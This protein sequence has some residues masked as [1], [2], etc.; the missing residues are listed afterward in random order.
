VTQ[1]AGALRAQLNLQVGT[2]NTQSVSPDSVSEFLSQTVSSLD[3]SGAEYGT[4]LLK[5]KLHDQAYAYAVVTFE[6]QQLSS[7]NTYINN[8]Q[9]VAKQLAATDESDTLAYA[10]LVEELA[11]REDQLS[12][13]IGDQFHASQISI[14][15]IANPD[16]GRGF[17]NEILNIYDSDQNNSDVI[18]QIAAIEVNFSKIFE[19][20]HNET[21][22]PHCIALAQ[23]DATSGF[24]E[25]EQP[26][27]S[28]DADDNDTG[29][30][31]D[32]DSKATTDTSDS[33]LEPLRMSTQWDF[34]GATN[35][36]ADGD[37][38]LTYSYYDGDVAYADPYNGN[39]G[40]PPANET[41]VESH[42]TGNEA[43]LDDAFAAWDL[44]SDFTFQEVEE[45]GGE[46]G[47]LRVAY[48]DEGTGAAAFA[49]APGSSAVSGDIWF[50]AGSIDI[51]GAIDFKSDGIDELSSYYSNGSGNKPGFNYFAALHEIGH[52]LGLSHP[53]DS[54]DDSSNGDDDLP[55]SQDSM[56]N[57]VMT[58][59][60]LDRNMILQFDTGTS[61][62]LPTYR[63]WASTPMLYD[64]EM[65][66][67]YYGAEDDLIDND[68][69]GTA[70]DTYTFGITD[71]TSWYDSTLTIQ[72]IVDSGGT[73]TIDTSALSRESVIDLTAG[74][75]SSIGIY[76]EADQVSY[77]ATT[78]GTSTAAIQSVVDTMDG[79]A[80]AANS[81][82]SAYDR[83]A[84]Y[85]GDYNVAIAHNAVI[86]NAIGGSAND[87][88]TGNSSNNDLSGRAGDDRIEGNGGDDTIDGGTHTTGDVAVY[89]GAYTE[90]TITDLGG[91][92]YT[93]DH[94]GGSGSDG[95]DTISNIEFLE[96]TDQTIDLSTW[97]TVTSTSTPSGIG[98]QDTA[99]DPVY[100]TSDGANVTTNSL[101]DVDIS[102]QA[103]ALSAITRL[104]S[105][106]ETISKQQAYMGAMQ[107]R[108]A[109]S[110][111]NLSKQSLM[112][113]AAIGRIMDTDFSSE[114]AELTKSMILSEAANYV[115]SGAQL[116]KS[117][118]LK[119]LK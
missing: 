78:L 65:M 41:T 89:N 110:I 75:L 66:E 48:T 87:T 42:G 103:G 73:D 99:G 102:T 93:V 56:R 74:S 13:F 91:G 107:N 94:T 36:D 12:S 46:V 84:L 112:T 18:G 34:A 108:L 71:V 1:F 81:Y 90:Y 37:P 20:L 11:D 33:R 6:E 57:T 88:I 26:R 38:I 77:W 69:D 24:N 86:E 95:T 28:L 109:A 30:I 85:T 83:S 50:E 115:L 98:S 63:I 100:A 17:Q 82:Y 68:S 111:S 64:V 15:A 105:V 114:M 113:E 101:A 40:G 79:Y 21:T 3:L 55:L 25:D 61:S 106:L 62:S 31:V 2:E 27:F 67:H 80:S 22:C 49:Y 8:V 52:A 54:G 35:L 117:N 104:D 29:S 70:N 23:Q 39:V 47:E 92:M 97:P 10:A 14:G 19:T 44:A 7:L 76:S 32:I 96:F 119:L 53:F 9:S 16:L 60:Q 116:S 72:T 4:L 58:Y 59:S 45:D 118:M 51:T 5:D 43:V